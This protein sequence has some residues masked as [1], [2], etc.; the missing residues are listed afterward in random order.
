MTFLGIYEVLSLIDE[1]FG[2]G[3]DLDSQRILNKLEQEHKDRHVIDR[4]QFK[5]IKDSYVR[6]E[7]NKKDKKRNM[8]YDDTVEEEDVDEIIELKRWST[9]DGLNEW[10]DELLGQIKK[11]KST[12]YKKKDI[13]EMLKDKKVRKKIDNRLT[14][15]IIGFIPFKK[16]VPKVVLPVLKS[17][18][19]YI[20]FISGDEMFDKKERQ[21]EAEI[22]KHE[23]E[24]DD[25]LYTIAEEL[26]D[27]ERK[28]LVEILTKNN[29]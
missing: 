2:Y 22:N 16:E 9:N 14:E 19:K 4:L 7:L 18:H 28:R 15:K 5:R 11:G 29:Y 20:T 21:I 25:K 13:E 12:A 8:K 23:N 10:D 3:Q 24:R 1:E 17:E 26:N 27:Y 6:K